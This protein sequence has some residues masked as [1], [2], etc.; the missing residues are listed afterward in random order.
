MK[1]TGGPQQRTWAKAGKRD[2]VW[3]SPWLT[4][5][6]TYR[7]GS[8]GQKGHVTQELG[9][10]M[11][12]VSLKLFPHMSLLQYI[13]QTSCTLYWTPM[14]Q[15]SLM[16]LRIVN[17]LPL[18][19][20]KLQKPISYTLINDEYIILHVVAPYEIWILQTQAIVRHSSYDLK[21]NLWVRNCFYGC[22]SF[23]VL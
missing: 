1:G 9:C 4:A 13:A 5:Q 22:E 21:K 20:N 10:P 19:S 23:A 17:V 8:P 2:R 14:T 15:Y 3:R 18:T 11:V 16:Y 6:T 12:N 7:M